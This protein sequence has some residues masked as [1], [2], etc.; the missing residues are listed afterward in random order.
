MINIEELAEKIMEYQADID[1]Y[2]LCDD[3]G[4]IETDEES[5]KAVLEEI[6]N[7]LQ[8]NPDDILK[9]LNENLEELELEDNYQERDDYKKT[10]EIIEEIEQFKEQSQEDEMEM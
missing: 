10:K 1:W 3:Y 2:G 8:T 6:Y 7:V 9:I 5:R 4:N